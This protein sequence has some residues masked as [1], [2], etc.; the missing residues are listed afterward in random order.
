MIAAVLSMKY[1]SFVWF[2]PPSLCFGEK[3]RDCC[4]Y[5]I[6]ECIMGNVCYPMLPSLCLSFL[7]VN[8]TN[9]LHAMCWKDSSSYFGIIALIEQRKPIKMAFVQD[10]WNDCFHQM[11]N[12]KLGGANLSVLSFSVSGRR[13]WSTHP[14]SDRMEH[15]MSSSTSSCLAALLLYVFQQDLRWCCCS[16]R[17]AGEFAHW[18]GS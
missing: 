14:H 13:K 9:V 18:F 15:P 17:P 16:L 8:H 10:L 2:A 5:T 11:G 7:H 6:G 3:R 4:Y 12:Q 1:V